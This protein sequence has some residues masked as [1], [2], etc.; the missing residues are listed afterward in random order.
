MNKIVRVEM[1]RGWVPG[2]VSTTYGLQAM[3]DALDADQVVIYIRHTGDK[4]ITV[5]PVGHHSDA[6]QDLNGLITIDN[7][8]DLTDGS[9][10][11]QSKA[12]NFNLTAGGVW[13]HFLGVTIAI[14]TALFGS[15]SVEVYADA[16]VLVEAKDLSAEEIERQLDPDNQV[17]NAGVDPWIIDRNRRIQTAGRA[18]LPGNNPAVTAG[19]RG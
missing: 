14:G 2:V 12:I 6:P 7:S 16:R 10:A 1:A 8:T 11:M 9:T 17:V 18:A 19:Y 3:V 15:G 13:H 4:T 5:Q